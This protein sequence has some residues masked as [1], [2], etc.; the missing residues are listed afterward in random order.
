MSFLE[1]G[2]SLDGTWEPLRLFL[3]CY[4]VLH[5][6][7]DERAEGILHN[8]YEKMQNW[9]SLIPDGEMR[10]IYLEEV[11]WHREIAAARSAKSLSG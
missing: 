6:V 3:T 2:G 1:G 4:Q 8:A 9:A 7:G 5:A 11:P 10:R